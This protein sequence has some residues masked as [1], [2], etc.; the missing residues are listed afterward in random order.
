M[1]CDGSKCLCSPKRLRLTKY[2]GSTTRENR[3]EGGPKGIAVYGNHLAVCNALVGIH[4]YAF[5]ELP[6]AM[7]VGA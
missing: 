5:R 4:I 2:S 6:A 7:G 3:Q 1:E